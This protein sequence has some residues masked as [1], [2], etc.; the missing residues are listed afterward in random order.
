MN[1]Q[2]LGV[3]YNDTEQVLPSHLART[4]CYSHVGECTLPLPVLAVACTMR[5]EALQKCCTSLWDIMEHYRA[6][7][8]V[9]EHYRSITG[10][11]GALQSIAG[12][13][14]TLQKLCGSVMECRGALW[15]IT[16]CCRTLQ[17]RRGSLQKATCKMRTCGPADRQRVKRGPKFADRKCGCV[18]KMRTKNL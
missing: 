17:N 18:G 6:L 10:C 14:R 9:T 15:N 13:Y 8:D 12:C 11:C 3:V 16:E 5:N 4:C 2:H 7:R 1:S